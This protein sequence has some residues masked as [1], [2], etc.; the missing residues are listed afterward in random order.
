MEQKLHWFN[1]VYKYDSIL[2][3]HYKGNPSKKVTKH[4]IEYGKS[5]INMPTNSV[6]ISCDYLGHMTTSEFTGGE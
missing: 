5:F 3:N 2:A 4:Q 1:L 6:L